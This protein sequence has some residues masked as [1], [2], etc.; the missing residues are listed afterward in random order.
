[1]EKFRSSMTFQ[2]LLECCSDIASPRWEAGWREFIKRYKKF[3]YNKVAQRCSIWGV[4]RIQR[5]FSEFV[6]EIVD[7]VFVTLCKNDCQALR[8]F[9][10]RENE[11]R[12]FAWL[13]TICERTASRHIRALLKESLLDE[14]KEEVLRDFHSLDSG[15]RWELHEMV[16][17]ELRTFSKRKI[18]NLERDIHI[19]QLYVLADFSETMVRAHPCLKTLSHGVVHNVIYRMRNILVQQKN[20]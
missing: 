12:F 10:A 4:P 5:Q 19:F 2:E 17:T 14:K 1:M 7:T 15:T 11:R 20:D 18:G 16:V 6:N 3:I 8:D 9:E 13:A